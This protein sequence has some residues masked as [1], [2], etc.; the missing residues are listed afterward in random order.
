MK[1]PNPI[2]AMAPSDTP[3]PMPALAPVESPLFAATAA[4]FE[5]E[6]D[7]IA[8]DETEED[9]E[10]LESDVADTIGIVKETELDEDGGAVGIGSPNRAA[11]VYRANPLPSVQQLSVDPQH[12]VNDPVSP[13]QG[14]TLMSTLRCDSRC[15]QSVLL[16]TASLN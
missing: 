4:V 2:R 6:A 11:M 1:T 9:T 16:L 5:P 14:V 15:P 7:G 12:Q 13:S 3:M 8:T 10:K